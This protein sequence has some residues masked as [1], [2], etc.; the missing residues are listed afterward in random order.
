VRLLFVATLLLAT[1]A[2]GPD[3]DRWTALLIKNET[4]KPLLIYYESG[5]SEANKILINLV[6]IDSRVAVRI[7]D[8]GHACHGL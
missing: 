3:G 6:E 4:E 8:S 1:A 5:G 2:C 7:L